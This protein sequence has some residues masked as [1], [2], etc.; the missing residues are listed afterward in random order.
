[1]CDISVIIP[2]YNS[3]KFINKCLDSVINQTFPSSRFEIICIND[4]STDQT[5]QI[6]TEYT[7]KYTNI[8]VI[9]QKNQGQGLARNVGVSIAKGKYVKFIDSDDYLHPNALQILYETAEQTK[10]DIVVCKAF[11]TDEYNQQF[12]QLT[13]WNHIIGYY[14][15]SEIV[16]IDFFNNI[17][18]PVLWD[19]LIKSNIAKTCL[20]PSLRRGQDFITL[21]KYISLCKSICFIDDRLYYYRHH[22]MSVMSE[23]ES[24]STII[25]DFI[26]ECTAIE[27]MK[28]HFL[29]TNAYLYYCER[30]KL[31]WDKRLKNKTLLCENEIKYIKNFISNLP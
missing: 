12:T 3:Q 26:T 11:C 22:S 4:G 8:I 15:K 6:L 18:S 7:L 29:K 13:M 2:I 10:A 9:N 24:K 16:K 30:I 1:M 27:L 5:P 17:C 28:Y 25:S 20:S 31:E 14:T 19:K 23:K 21:L